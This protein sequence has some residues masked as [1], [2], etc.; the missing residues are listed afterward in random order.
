MFYKGFKD[1]LLKLAVSRYEME[2]RGDRG[3]RYTSGKA[4]RSRREPT[5]GKNLTAKERFVISRSMAKKAN[6]DMLAYYRDHPDKLSEKLER[7][8]KKKKKK[9]FI[10]KAGPG[11]GALAGLGVSLATHR[12]LL[13]GIGTGATLG[14]IPDISASLVEA[15]KEKERG[16][17]D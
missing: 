17:A 14:W 8:K 4:V 5:W 9:S 15:I 2:S 10:R 1:E 11:L 3:H 13:T 6:G 16:K 12:P 7:D